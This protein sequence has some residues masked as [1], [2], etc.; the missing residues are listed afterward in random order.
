MERPGMLM[1]RVRNALVPGLYRPV[2]A[3]CWLRLSATL[4]SNLCFS[5]VRTCIADPAGCIFR[6]QRRLVAQRAT[7]ILG[8]LPAVSASGS[9]APRPAAE[10]ELVEQR[11]AEILG[12][13][14]ACRSGEMVAP[15]TRAEVVSQ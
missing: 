11:S 2:Y 3:W 10:M 13:I 9:S 5:S 14:S 12:Q 8:P 4:I 1:R 6:R 15:H 7:E